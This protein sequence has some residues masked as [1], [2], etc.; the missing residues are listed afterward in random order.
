MTAKNIVDSFR[1]VVQDLLVPEVRALNVSVDSLRSEMNLGHERLEQTIRLGI[2]NT[3][4]AIRSLSE[5]LEFAIDIR[6]RLAALEARFP[7]Q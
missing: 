3:N 6:E 4:Q 5:K 7:R 1:E 2:E